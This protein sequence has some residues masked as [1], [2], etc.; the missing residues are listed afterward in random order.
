MSIMDIFSFLLVFSVGWFGGQWYMAY[1]LKRNIT[2]IAEKYGM[3]F[4]EWSD[5]LSNV[6]KHTNTSV[7]V[8]V[9][10]YEGSNIYLYNKNTGSFVCQGD[11]LEELARIVKKEYDTCIVTDKEQML[12]FVDG[13]VQTNLNES[14]TS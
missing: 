13:K 3:T 14:K 4:D 6:V 5:S 2:K 1:Q 10:E 11:S 8:M 9:T 7:P 12:L